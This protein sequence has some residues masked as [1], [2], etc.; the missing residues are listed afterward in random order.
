[1]SEVMWLNHE[2]TTLNHVR[3]RIDFSYEDFTTMH[4]SSK[5]QVL[6]AWG[7]GFKKVISVFP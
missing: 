5:P 4:I 1:M 3:T 2:P 7:N 6:G